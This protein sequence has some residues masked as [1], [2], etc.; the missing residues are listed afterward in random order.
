MLWPLTWIVVAGTLPGVIGGGFIRLT[1]LPDPKPFKMFVGVVLLY[2][3]ARIFFDLVKNRGRKASSSAN[4]TTVIQQWTAKTLDPSWRWYSFEFQGIVYE[5]RTEGIFLISLIVGIIGGVYGIGG[6]TIIAPFFVAV[7]RLP[8]HAV[9]GATLMGTFVTS[10]VGVAF[11]ELV[12][13]LYETS[14]MAVSPDWALGAL[15]GLGGLL[16]MYLGARTQRF[17]SSMWLKLMLGLILVVVAVR[18]IMGFFSN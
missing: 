17:V 6:G 8:V 9:A 1:Y 12:S 15:F 11:Y 4:A 3:G 13:P 5:C 18:Y 16:G 10:I 7:Y 2:I 14:E